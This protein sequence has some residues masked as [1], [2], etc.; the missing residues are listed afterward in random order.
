MLICAC[1]T[2]GDVCSIALF[3]DATELA[4]WSFRHD[5]KLSERL[6]PLVKQMLHEQKSATVRDVDAW[7]VGLG[8]GSFTGVRIGVTL[9]QNAGVGDK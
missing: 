7:A 3:E 1:D 6:A 8:P 2:S 4:A 9:N 5:R